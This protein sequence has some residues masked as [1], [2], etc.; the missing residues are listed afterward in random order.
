MAAKT[1][2]DGAQ[3]ARGEGDVLLRD[4][5][6]VGVVGDSERVFHARDGAELFQDAVVVLWAG[7]RVKIRRDPEES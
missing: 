5:A 1:C 4:T 2:A 7:V 3:N 6:S